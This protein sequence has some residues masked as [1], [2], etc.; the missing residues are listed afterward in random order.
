[1]TYGCTTDLPSMAVLCLHSVH[2]LLSSVRVERLSHMRVCITEL[3]KC[4][5]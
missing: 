3:L 2:L 5:K 4:F 1:M